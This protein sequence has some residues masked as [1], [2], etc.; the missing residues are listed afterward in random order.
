M[1]R[2]RSN[3]REFDILAVVLDL[4]L[5][6]KSRESFESGIRSVLPKLDGEYA[7]VVRKW[8][9]HDGSWK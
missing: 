6:S 8:T 5:P 9:A 3:D 4:L 2:Y 7:A 1:L